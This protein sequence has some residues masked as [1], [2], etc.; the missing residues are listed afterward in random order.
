[1]NLPTPAAA[2]ESAQRP[3]ISSHTILLLCGVL[4]GMCVSGNISD[5]AKTSF[6]FAGTVGL[7]AFTGLSMVKR[8]QTHTQQQVAIMQAEERLDRHSQCD[9]RN[10]DRVVSSPA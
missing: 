6:L 9:S 10:S 4:F 7:I 3:L 1:M 5:E 8:V 2:S